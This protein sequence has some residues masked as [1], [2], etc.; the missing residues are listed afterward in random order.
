LGFFLGGLA[1]GALRPT[2]TWDIFVYL[3]L[4]VVALVYSGW[5]WLNVDA[6]TF[7]GTL[8]QDLPAVVKRLL[9]VAGQV[10]LLVVLSLLLYLPYARWYA[11]GYN[12]LRLWDGTTTPTGAYLIHWG[13]FLFFI[14]TWMAWETRQWMAD[15]PLV[16]LRKLQ[17]YRGL[18]IGGLV[19]LLGW[20][21]IL[22]WLDI[23]IAWLV[24][25]LMVWAGLLLLRPAMSDLK[26]LVLF[27]VGTGLLLTLVVEVVV[28]RGDIGRMNTV[29]KF[30]LQVWTLFAVSAAASF[31][32]L[33]ES[34]FAWKRGWRAAWQA[35][36]IFL[37]GSALLFALFAAQAK[38]TDRM[39]YY[40]QHRQTEASPPLSLDGLKYMQYAKY[41]EPGPNDVEGIDMDLS[42]DYRMIRWLQDNVE[43][44]PVIVEAVSRNN[45]RWYGRMSIN[46]GLPGVVGWEW[47]QQQ[48]RA[49]NPGEW[50]TERVEDVREFYVTFDA[51]RF[52]H[53]LNLYD[54]SYIILG[55]L[56]RAAF[57]GPGLEKFEDF[58][59]IL[60]REVYRDGDNV[61]YQVLK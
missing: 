54:V 7:H 36:A 51:E 8:L 26:R 30:Y 2:N 38:I 13:L 31:G 17:K 34:L 14:V 37:V 16:A 32:W 56:E 52:T 44:S 50:V 6:G 12:S 47:H 58:D 15:T 41:Y 27:M 28:L 21:A 60:W 59:G 42:Q 11:L 18:L 1:I 10:L 4:A 35:T 22:L 46:T 61:I 55:Q 5:R 48:Q 43:G 19:L 9:L 39:T 3:G 49:I 25:P 20:T 33:L 53:F 23:Y 24:L 45:Y 29:F 40:S 57:P